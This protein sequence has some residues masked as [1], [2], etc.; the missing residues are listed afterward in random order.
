MFIILDK[1]Y[2]LA[3]VQMGI[4]KKKC[5]LVINIIKILLN[6]LYVNPNFYVHLIFNKELQNKYW[7]QNIVSKKCCWSNDSSGVKDRKQIFI[8]RPAQT[9][10][11]MGQRSL[12]KI[13]Y[14]ESD[15]VESRKL[16]IN[17]QAGIF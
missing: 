7:S 3:Q 5:V 1:H 9:R 2:Y 11:Q 15:R 14:P 16:R 10:L 13:W 4:R 6:E 12:S 8:A 17:A